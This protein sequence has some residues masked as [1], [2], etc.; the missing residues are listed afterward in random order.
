MRHPFDLSVTELKT[1]DL[2]FE[3]DLMLDAAEAVAGGLTLTTLAL[4]EEGGRGDYFP[5]PPKV[6]P[7]CPRP[8]PIP[9]PEMT[10][11]ALGEEGGVTTL[12]LGE[13]GGYPDSLL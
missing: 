1:L 11:M 5:R 8:V 12:A 6:P 7:I 2:D 3:E 9:P 13:E 4:G 10:T